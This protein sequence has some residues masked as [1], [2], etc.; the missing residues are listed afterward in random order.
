MKVKPVLMSTTPSPHPSTSPCPH[1]LSTSP[2][3]PLCPHLLSTSP[4]LL[5]TNL[6]LFPHLYLL[7]LLGICL[8][9]LL[10]LPHP[11]LHL[12]LKLHLL[13]HL[14]KLIEVESLLDPTPNSTSEKSDSTPSVKSTLIALIIL[15]FAD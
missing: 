14:L 6:H 10:T 2:H 9:L 4:H 5:S 11:H 13:L 1:L 7:T 12:L 15:L 8:H 3:L